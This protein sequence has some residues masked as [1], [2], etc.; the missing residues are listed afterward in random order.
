MA[1]QAFKARLGRGRDRRWELAHTV[2]GGE[3]QTA[4]QLIL[5]VIA[6]SIFGL[7]F[8]AYLARWV[9]RHSTGSEAM[10]R[11]SNAIKEGAEAFLRRQN[12]TIVLL[13]GL[14]AVVLFIGY[15]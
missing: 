12:R 3:M 15:G 10:Q 7:F 6:F 9:L 13:A 1:A 5:L 4:T 2:G 14:F 8:A 11:I